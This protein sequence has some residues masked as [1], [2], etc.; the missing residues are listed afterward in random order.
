[1]FKKVREDIVNRIAE[2]FIEK[3]VKQDME[4]NK[5]C[6][7]NQIATQIKNR[8]EEFWSV[9]F[10][11]MAKY[12]S[13][14]QLHPRLVKIVESEVASQLSNY[15][16]EDIIKILPKET[17]YSIIISEM[18]KKMDII[19]NTSFKNQIRKVVNQSLDEV[20]NK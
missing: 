9:Y 5:N 4:N 15:S 3:Y 11:H 19:I 2:I 8:V 16:E 13:T 17:I 1:M 12:E 14:Q 20:L 7:D 6:L 18:D 10:H